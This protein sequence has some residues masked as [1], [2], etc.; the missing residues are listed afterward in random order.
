ME[1]IN[2]YLN[3]I[4]NQE[5]KDFSNIKY[6]NNVDNMDNMDTNPNQKSGNKRFF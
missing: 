4:S 3:L 5:I 1:K 6:T 2:K